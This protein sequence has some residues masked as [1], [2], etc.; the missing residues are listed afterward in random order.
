MGVKQKST[1][2]QITNEQSI[3]AAVG[4]L[5]EDPKPSDQQDK[6]IQA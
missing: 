6:A 1:A 4:E 5:F 3:Q 2:E